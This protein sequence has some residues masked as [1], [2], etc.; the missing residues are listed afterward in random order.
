M[1]DLTDLWGAMYGDGVEKT[2]SGTR[3]LKTVARNAKWMEPKELTMERV[4]AAL[5]PKWRSDTWRLRHQALTMEGRAN[6]ALRAQDDYLKG[7]PAY[8]EHK[9][10]AKMHGQLAGEIKA[11]NGK[12]DMRRMNAGRQG[13]GDADDALA[14]ATKGTS[15]PSAGK[16]PRLPLRVQP[17]GTPAPA[18]R[19]PAAFGGPENGLKVIPKKGKVGDVSRAAEERRA[20]AYGSKKPDGHPGFDDDL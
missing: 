6:Q 18:A 11:P 16:D 14:E 10:R 9:A 8:V 7:Q 4:R 5:P 13:K 20:A 3:Y 15:L 19:M 12:P 1:S 17:P 2:A